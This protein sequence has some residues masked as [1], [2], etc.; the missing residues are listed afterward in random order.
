[1]RG[2]AVTLKQSGNPID[3]S[4][5]Y[6]ASLMAF[7]RKNLSMT[8]RKPYESVHWTR[9]EQHQ[10]LTTCGVESTGCLQCSSHLVRNRRK[11]LE[12]N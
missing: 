5:N 9:V 7:N 12:P 1:M 10:V 6:T 2:Q 3:Q 8:S 11:W 4:C